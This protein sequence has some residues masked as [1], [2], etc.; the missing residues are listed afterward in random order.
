MV[1]VVVVVMECPELLVVMASF[2]VDPT[3]LLYPLAPFRFSM[4]T[5]TAFSFSKLPHSTALSALSNNAS[6]TFSSYNAAI[7]RLN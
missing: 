3:H 1:V 7:S 4:K 5:T 2:V 6:W